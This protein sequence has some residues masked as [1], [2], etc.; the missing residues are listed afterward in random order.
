VAVISFCAADR[1]PEHLQHSGISLI[2]IKSHDVGIAIDTERELGQIVRANRKPVEQP[3]KL[4]D[5]NH[6]VRT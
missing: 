4:I 3:R 2:E 6:I 1:H 5:Q